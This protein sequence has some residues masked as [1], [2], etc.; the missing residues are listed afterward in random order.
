MNKSWDFWDTLVT[1]VVHRPDEVFRIV[2]YRAKIPGFYEERIKAEERSR[3][4]I[5]ETSID[6]IY[7]FL[8][9]NTDDLQKLKL[10]EIET[11]ILL[12]SVVSEN[13]S[14]FSENDWVLSDMYLCDKTIRRIAEKCNIIIKDDQLLVSSQHDATKYEGSLFDIAKNMGMKNISGHTGDNIVG[15]VSVPNSKGI[16]AIHYKSIEP[17]K[18][19][20]KWLKRLGDGKYISGILRAARLSKPVT[21]R[22]NDTEWEIYSQIVAPVLVEFVSWILEE[23]GKKK[24]KNIYFLSR[25]GQ[26]LKRIAD[27]L[28]V[29]RG[30][31]IKSN[32]LY[33]SR[34]SFHLPGH[35]DINESESWLLDNTEKLTLNIIAKRSGVSKELFIAVAHKYLNVDADKNLSESERSILKKIIRDSSFI[36]LIEDASS[37]ALEPVLYYFGQSGLLQCKYEAVAIVDVG[38]NMRIQRSLENILQKNQIPVNNI[39]GYYFGISNNNVFSSGERVKGFVYDPFDSKK[40]NGKWVDLYR[41]MVE[42]FLG[43]DHPS[44][45]SFFINSQGGSE[46]VFLK[47]INEKDLEHV[48]FMQDAVLSYTEKLCIIEKLLERSLRDNKKFAVECFREFLEKPSLK[49]AM[50]FK[51]YEHTEQQV[52]SDFEPMVKKLNIKQMLLGGFSQNCGIW[53]AGS[54][55][56]SHSFL[57]YRFRRM[58]SYLKRK[59]KC[60]KS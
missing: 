57:F 6:R 15:D 16:N 14:A 54:H 50:V 26:I 45:H 43:A 55:V 13:A 53:P 44:V 20:R 24:I 17:N 8:P 29:S 33:A 2:E 60:K 4:G 5:S 30:L 49:Q 22:K 52:E 40:E 12:A 19:E 48:S 47:R 37:E 58:L 46:P 21:N 51:E 11:E 25:D 18:L 3:V 38:W 39:F 28:I 32:Y 42:F 27:A 34:Q 56:I 9:Y 59:I 23:S 7:D 10:L 1:R 31:S 36:K 41:G 35:M